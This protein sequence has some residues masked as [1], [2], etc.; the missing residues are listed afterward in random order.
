ML[1]SLASRFSLFFCRFSSASRSPVIHGKSQARM[2]DTNNM[3]ARER[4][5]WR[6][7]RT[8]R[9]GECLNAPRARRPA[10]SLRR[11]VATVLTRTSLVERLLIPPRLR[12]VLL[13]HWPHTSSS[14]FLALY[15]QTKV[16]TGRGHTRTRETQQS[17]TVRQSRRPAVLLALAFVAITVTL[18]WFQKKYILS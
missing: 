7:D 13:R 2:N 3:S 16:K 4:Q 15:F 9:R 18:Q 1:R 11:G 10:S 14:F 17:E 8:S 6:V 12:I 5:P